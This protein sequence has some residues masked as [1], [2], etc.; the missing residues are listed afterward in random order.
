M[1][2]LRE[3]LSRWEADELSQVGR[4]HCDIQQ[5]PAGGVTPLRHGGSRLW[6]LWMTPSGVADGVHRRSNSKSGHFISNLNRTSLAVLYSR[7]ARRP[8]S[9]GHPIGKHTE[10]AFLSAMVATRTATR[11]SPPRTTRDSN[12]ELA[13]TGW[14]HRLNLLEH[15]P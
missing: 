10:S 9:P 8:V 13:M 11:Q 2:K 6:V 5:F 12:T 4:R 14:E 15:L 1:F 3:V 7:A